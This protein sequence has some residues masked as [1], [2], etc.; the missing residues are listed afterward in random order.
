MIF[1]LG[2]Q[3]PK[4]NLFA[5]FQGL[6]TSSFISLDTSSF[7]LQGTTSCI[8]DDITLFFVSPRFSCILLQSIISFKTTIYLQ[9]QQK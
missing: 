5:Y 2:L 6:Y 3:T 1:R 8:S 7:M 4:Y 9:W